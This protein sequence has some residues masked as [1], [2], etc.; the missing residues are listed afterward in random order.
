[1]K[2]GRRLA[3]KL[4]N[5]SKFA[6]R[7]GGDDL[8]APDAIVEPLDRS[9]LVKL[10]GLV[11]ECTAA[12]DA[13]DY[14]RALERTETFFWTFCDDYLELVKAR[15]YGEQGDAGSAQATLLTALE[16][17]LELFAPFLPFVTEEIWSW[18]RQGSVHTA[19]WPDADAL[20]QL[21][22]DADALVLEV[23]AAVLSEARKAKTEAKQSL[24]AP[25]DHL[26]VR[27]V[28]DRLAA[29]ALVAD[30]LRAAGSIAELRS[31]EGQTFAVEAT[32]AS[33]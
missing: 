3:I 33:P 6:L 32:L 15:A 7:L 5:A 31:E 24:K 25:V 17:L 4:L 22:G 14:A 8:V 2:V 30:D 23:G 9:L 1:M 13:Y 18:W 29:L 19:S 16:S 28:A 26:V 20:R 21:A 11:D 27:D 12:F 10:A